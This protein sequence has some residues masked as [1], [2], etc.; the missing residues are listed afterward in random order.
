MVQPIKS[1]NLA[2]Y[3]LHGLI[4]TDANDAVMEVGFIESR[5]TK[6]GL[7]IWYNTDPI[8]EKTDKK[9]YLSESERARVCGHSDLLKKYYKL[10]HDEC[11]YNG[12]DTD[13]SDSM[14]PSINAALINEKY[15]GY[16]V[17][18]NY[19][20]CAV[21]GRLSGYPKLE[22]YLLDNL[23]R[24][25]LNRQQLFDYM[26]RQLQP[27]EWEGFIAA[28]DPDVFFNLIVGRIP[29]TYQQTQIK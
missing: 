11:Q 14:G 4:L 23:N 5:P 17:T 29:L 7:A 16:K 25:F 24:L 15:N 9:R 19:E 6:R 20:N 12:E 10:R 22:A 28:M 27:D 8:M 2:S 3:P 26:H 13:A 1:T 21:P 18:A